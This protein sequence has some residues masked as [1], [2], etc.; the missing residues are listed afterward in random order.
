MPDEQ[1]SHPELNRGQCG[2]SATTRHS[3]DP[4]ALCNLQRHLLLWSW[5]RLVEPVFRRR[6]DTT[7]RKRR[8]AAVDR[9]LL[10]MSR[11][12]KF[13][14][15]CRFAKCCADDRIAETRFARRHPRFSAEEPAFSRGEGR[16]DA[17]RWPG[18][19]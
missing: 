2:E 14:G 19:R 18:Q 10:R 11:D 9:P 15:G 5:S 7:I 1:F 4:I 6:T 16:S 8:S 17:A 12:A 13:R 3:A